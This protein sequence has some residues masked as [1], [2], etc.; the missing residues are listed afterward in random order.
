MSVATDQRCVTSQKVEDFIYFLHLIFARTQ[1]S[2]CEQLGG[3]ILFAVAVGASF[4]L[5]NS[6]YFQ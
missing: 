2:H 5:K 4:W 6:T 1:T 3:H